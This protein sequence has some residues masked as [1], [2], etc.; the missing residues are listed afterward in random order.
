MSTPTSINNIEAYITDLLELQP[1]ADSVDL[2][3]QT[4]YEN[5]TA[6]ES[7]IE[8][9]DESYSLPEDDKYLSFAVS[10][11]D[12]LIPANQ[13]ISV[14]SAADEAG[15]RDY[16]VHQVDKLLNTGWPIET[17]AAQ[18]VLLLHGDVDFAIRVD[19]I[20]GL[21]S[22]PSERFLVRKKIKDRPW[23]TAISRDFQSAL[24]NSYMLGR[25]L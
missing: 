3:T 24:L 10:G 20:H 4:D 9:R 18:F 8:V 13:V 15:F 5:D 7:E 25:S 2:Q 22:V 16:R 19:M 23:F 11:S 12:F 6:S 21:V 17:K 14:K 1:S